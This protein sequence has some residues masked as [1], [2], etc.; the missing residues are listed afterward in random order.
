MK[1]TAR[2]HRATAALTADSVLSAEPSAAECRAPS[3]SVSECR[4]LGTHPRSRSAGG[5]RLAY[6]VEPNHDTESSAYFD[7]M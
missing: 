4:A 3:A 5:E 1:V 2:T 6:I 7:M